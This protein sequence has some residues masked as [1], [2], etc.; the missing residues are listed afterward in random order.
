MIHYF[1]VEGEPR[2]K[3]RPR[4]ANGHAYTPIETRQYEDAVRFQYMASGG[5]EFPLRVQMKIVAYYS[6]PKTTTKAVRKMML[7]GDILPTRKPDCDN[8]LKIIADALNGIAYKDDAQ[9]NAMAI[10]KRYSE[11]PCVAVW[12]TDEGLGAIDGMVE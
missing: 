12:L 8:I 1:C 11:T 5:K 4:V 10:E 9:V 6:I 2:G 7:N 3:Q